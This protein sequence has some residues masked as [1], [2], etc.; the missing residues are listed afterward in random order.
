MFWFGNEGVSSVAI[1]TDE[2]LVKISGKG[3][4]DPSTFVTTIAKA[5]KVAQFQTMENTP[6]PTAAPIIFIDSNSNHPSNSSGKSNDPCS[7]TTRSQ[8]TNS[9][10]GHFSG[11]IHV[12]EASAVIPPVALP[13]HNRMFRQ[14]SPL[15]GGASCSRNGGSLPPPNNYHR[16]WEPVPP[17]RSMAPINGYHRLS[18]PP[19][20]APINGYHQLSEPLPYYY[21]PEQPPPVGNAARHYMFNDENV[22]GCVIV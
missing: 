7:R 10:S 17:P 22:E 16:R 6:P 4:L 5:G 21:Y 18:E 8:N 3:N 1:D 11:D 14:P 9:N 12:N 2:G 15:F 19:S 13:L 20:M